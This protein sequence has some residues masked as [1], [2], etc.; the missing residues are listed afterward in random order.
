MQERIAI[1]LEKASGLVLMEAPAQFPCDYVAFRPSETQPSYVVEVKH[2]GVSWQRLCEWGTYKIS[3][4]KITETRR[5]YDDVP[6]LL[7][8]V[9][10]DQLKCALVHREQK[11]ATCQWGR[12][13][14]GDPQD[15]G[16]A[17][18]IP[19]EAF[20]DPRKLRDA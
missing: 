14:R 7:A 16:L 2:R 9:F 13:D 20:F 8:I 5:H 11:L 3:Y 19:C 18:M 17:A 1:E 4:N 6:L 12:T 15:V 10:R